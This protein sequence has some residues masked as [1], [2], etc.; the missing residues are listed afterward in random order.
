MNRP[1][2]AGDDFVPLDVDQ[3]TLD[4]ELASGAVG[5]P[6][7]AGKWAVQRRRPLVTDHQLAGERRLLEDAEHE[8]EDVVEQAGDDAAVRTPRCSLVGR[9][10]CQQAFHFIA[11]A[12]HFEVE[13][14]G[15]ERPENGRSS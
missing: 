10:E 8:A 7:A 13:P 15:D 1:R 5:E 14:P 9:A 2:S 4:P 11:T 6:P 12:V 3:L